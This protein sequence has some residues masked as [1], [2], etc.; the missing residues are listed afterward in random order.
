MVN[1]EEICHRCVHPFYLLEQTSCPAECPET[2]FA[3]KETENHN[4]CE[5][6]ETGC[7]TCDLEACFECYNDGEDSA[8]EFYLAES[9][10]HENCD[11]FDATYE[12]I[13]DILNLGT[14]ENC[15]PVCEICTDNENC[16][17]CGVH[18]QNQHFEHE[19]DC[20]EI[21][22]ETFYEDVNLA[23]VEG[24][25][26][27]VATC[28]PCGTGVKICHEEIVI[29]VL[30]GEED[31]EIEVITAT[32]CLPGFLLLDGQCITECPDGYTVGTVVND[33]GVTVAACLKCPD[34]CDDCDITSGK[35]NECI[36]D[37]ETRK[38]LTVVSNRCEE[39]CHSGA[40]E[41]KEYFEDGERYKG[42]CTP[43]NVEHCGECDA[44]K[45]L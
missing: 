39:N 29:E 31:K 44:N 11:N 42:T 23:E 21:C 45:C 26:M 16:I 19:G 25:E 41:T 6:C 33:E 5:S 12:S 1:D 37:S 40:R 43:C 13:D 8:R 17:V 30:E 15:G 18:E 35:C 9:H 24:V 22:P 28:E 14:C 27:N 2:D 7:R 4:T 34:D 38:F 3:E 10:C 36:G 20:I 32:E